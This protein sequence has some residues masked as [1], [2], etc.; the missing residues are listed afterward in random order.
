LLAARRTYR[1]CFFLAS[2]ARLAAMHGLRSRG[3]IA[4]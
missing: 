1:K 3:R 4:D 2:R